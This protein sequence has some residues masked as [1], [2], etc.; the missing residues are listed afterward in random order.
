LLRGQWRKHRVRHSDDS[1]PALFQL[2]GGWSNL[3]LQASVACSDID[4]L[5]GFQTQRLPDRFGDDDTSGGIYRG[6][7]ARKNGMKMVGEQA[8]FALPK[9]KVSKSFTTLM[10]PYWG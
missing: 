6:F 1:S 4:K 9:D 5:T 7:H 10:R 2:H 8:I 3:D